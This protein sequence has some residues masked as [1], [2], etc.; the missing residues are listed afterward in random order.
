MI[1]VPF[2]QPCPKFASHFPRLC[3]R[4]A[5]ISQLCPGSG[6]IS[7]RCPRF[8]SFSWTLTWVW[9]QQSW[10]PPLRKSRTPRRS[11]P[12]TTSQAAEKLRLRPVCITARLQCLRENS[13]DDL[14]VGQG[15]RIRH[16]PAAQ[17]RQ[18]CE[19]GAQAPGKVGNFPEPRSGDRVLT[20]TLQSGR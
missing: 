13:S 15:R 1:C 19:P 14:A 17:R 16:N 4:F 3:P 10:T 9:A 6:P 18:R 20:H 12:G 8:A 7:Q 5:S 2:P 11:T